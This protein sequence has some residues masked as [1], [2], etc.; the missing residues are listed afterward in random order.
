MYKLSILTPT[1]SSKEVML[2]HY[3]NFKKY[4]S[5]NIEL[6]VVDQGEFID[7]TVSSL[8]ISDSSFIYIHSPR[9]GLSIN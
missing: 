3:H 7:E 9:K 4:S 6:I 5:P 8:S 1:L 2:N